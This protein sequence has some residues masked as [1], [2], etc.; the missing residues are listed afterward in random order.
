MVLR[1]IRV[2]KLFRILRSFRFLR[3]RPEDVSREVSMLAF[4]IFCLIFTSA[5]FYQLVENDM[6]VVANEPARVPFHEAFYFNAIEILGRPRIEPETVG[7][8]LLLILVV[9]AA[10]VIIPWQAASNPEGG[11]SIYRCL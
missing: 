9:T 1:V 11:G 4:G 3:N 5:G 7:A 6:R 2:T 8:H 10:Y